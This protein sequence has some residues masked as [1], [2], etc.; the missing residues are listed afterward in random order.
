MNILNEDVFI[1][2]FSYLNPDDIIVFYSCCNEFQ[3][4]LEQ[5]ST[6]KGFVVQSKVILSQE[7]I[8]WFQN[9]NIKLKLLDEYCLMR[10]THH[11]FRNGELHRDGD[12]PAKIYSDGSCQWYR[13]GLLH[14]DNDLPAINNHIFQVWYQNGK[15]HRDNDMPAEISVDGHKVWY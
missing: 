13:N 6:H 3:T 8:D 7:I 9:Q 1:E 10:D 12:L 5:L 2:I 11:W 15:R 14:R 4:I